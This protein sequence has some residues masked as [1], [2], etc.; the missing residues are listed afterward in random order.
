M[1]LLISITIYM[2]RS[3]AHP[4][5]IILSMISLRQFWNLLTPRIISRRSTF[6]RGSKIMGTK[7]K[8]RIRE[9]VHRTEK[10][11]ATHENRS[12]SPGHI[13][14]NMW[15]WHT[16][17]IKKN[18]W[19][20][21]GWSHLYETWC[22]K[23]HGEYWAYKGRCPTCRYDL[24]PHDFAV[25]GRPQF[26]GVGFKVWITYLRVAL[27]LPYGNINMIIQDMFNEDISDPLI[28]QCIQE[29]ARYHSQTEKT[30]FN[31]LLESPS[32]MPMRLRWISIMWISIYGY[33][34]TENMS[35]SNIQKQSGR[36]S[37]WILGWLPRHFNIRFF[38]GYDS[39]NCRHQ[40]C[41]VH[42]IRDLNNDLWASPF[43]T[44][45]EDLVVEVKN[46]IIPIMESIQKYGLK[47]RHLSQFTNHINIF[48]KR[49]IDQKN[50]KSDLCLK[51]QH[52]FLRYRKSLF[53]FLEYDGIPWHNNTAESAIRHLPLQQRIS[54][55]SIHLLFESIWFYSVSSRHAAFKRNHSWNY[56]FRWAR[57][58]QI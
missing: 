34:L 42:L 11:I 33:L 51:Y 8:K 32:S 5:L 57:C 6:T 7:K 15:M 27:R 53:T 13:L 25:K 38:P 19:K 29:V 12:N 46:L 28:I 43:D 14:C 21:V 31:H 26:F 47:K 3:L 58:R 4:K 50:Y 23:I 30:I 9:L 41:L 56:A 2:Q 22:T 35:F 37:S 16:F 24:V 45:Y 55:V 52:R 49:V 44:E 20:D 10:S 40:K 48:Y 36:F 39:L 1:L 54:G 17:S 18:D